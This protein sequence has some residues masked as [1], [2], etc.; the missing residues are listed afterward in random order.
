MYFVTVKID[1]IQ[2]RRRS[3]ALLHVVIGLFLLTK[4]SDYYKYIE[5]KSFLPV[6]PVFA[7]SLFSII[8]GIFK[9]QI[10]PLSQWN[11][12]LRLAQVVSFTFLII[13]FLKLGKPLDYWSVLFFAALTILLLFSERRIFNE[14]IIYFDENGIRIPGS[15]REHLVEWR[16]VSEVVVR[17]DFLTIFHVGKKYLQFQVMQDLSTL[18]IVK[19]N[20][21]CKER[22][23]QKQEAGQQREETNE[24]KG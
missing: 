6:L 8:Y 11:Y 17:E 4:G 14:T 1:D 16:N 10:D 18:E 2:K 22:I 15:Y 9:R 7:V 3:A 5:Y 21:F 23:E 20:A 12:W 13:V 24:H 19:M